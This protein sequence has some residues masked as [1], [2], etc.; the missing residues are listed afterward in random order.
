MNSIRNLLLILSNDPE[1]KGIRYNALADNI[2]FT[3]KAPW[4]R[5]EKEFW[6]DQDDAQLMAYLEAHY[7]TFSDRNFKAGLT[8]IA[9]DRSY[10]PIKQW[11]DALP[12]W[13]GT[14]RLDTLL[15]ITLGAED[16][17]YIRAVT[18]KTF[19]A[20]IARVKHPGIRIK[21]GKAG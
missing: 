8:K 16:T 11:L 1:L 17:P 6:R 7:G 15:Y 2:E 18:R 10:H 19:V 9:D 14:E 5:P 20:A 4:G 3:G 21:G 12:K 13:D